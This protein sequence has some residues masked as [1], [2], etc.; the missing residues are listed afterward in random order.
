MALCGPCRGECE[1]EVHILCGCQE[2]GAGLGQMQIPIPIFRKKKRPGRENAQKSPSV[3]KAVKAVWGG[4]GV[5]DRKLCWGPAEVIKEASTS[6]RTR[7]EPCREGMLHL[8][9][10]QKSRVEDR[11][12]GLTLHPSW[13]KAESS[14]QCVPVLVSSLLLHV[15]YM[16]HTCA[17]IHS[18]MVQNEA[19]NRLLRITLAS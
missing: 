15:C 12:C 16:T 17:H 7:A 13:E 6:L 9:Q 19:T 14:K 2:G 1:R 8:P 10:P 4:M 3:Q 11:C 5:D 18:K